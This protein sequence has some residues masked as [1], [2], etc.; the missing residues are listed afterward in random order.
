MNIMD[1]TQGGC[2]SSGPYDPARH[3]WT[4]WEDYAEA[5]VTIITVGP[6][7]GKVVQFWEDRQKRTC[8]KC[9]MRD[10]QIVRQG[11]R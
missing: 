5:G 3:D 8:T 1:M 6:R 7:M 9:G 2:N 10:D 11:G 4:Q